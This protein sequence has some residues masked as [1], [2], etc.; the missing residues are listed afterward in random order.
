MTIARKVRKDVPLAVGPSGNFEN[1][2]GTFMAGASFF[3]AVVF[4]ARAALVPL[5]SGEEV[6]W[7]I[8]PFVTLFFGLG[9]LGLVM[10][11]R[12][13]S[14]VYP[15]GWAPPRKA[16]RRAHNHRSLLKWS[17]IEVIRMS[18]RDVEIYRIATESAGMLVT[19][20]SGE[21]FRVKLSELG[22]DVYRELLRRVPVVI[23]PD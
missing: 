23:A 7:P 15:D 12:Q 8:V 6:P 20:R 17:E 14:T 1:A 9:A 5:V 18:R 10:R 13:T 4:L 22:P 3:I 16:F 21:D 11:L 19:L 2:T